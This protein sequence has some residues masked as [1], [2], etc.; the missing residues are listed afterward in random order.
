LANHHVHYDG[1]VTPAF[2]CDCGWRAWLKLRNYF[3]GEFAPDLAK[4]ANGNGHRS[5]TRR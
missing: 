5:E 4:G 1:I 2:E 3:Y